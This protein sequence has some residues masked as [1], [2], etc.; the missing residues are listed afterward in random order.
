LGIWQLKA[1]IAM[2]GPITEPFREYLIDDAKPL[3]SS[4]RMY[5]WLY[6]H[7]AQVLV[8]DAARLHLR[9]NCTFCFWLMK[10]YPLAFLVTF[11]EPAERQFAQENLDVFGQDAIGI[12]RLIRLHLRPS[13]HPLWPEA[14]GDES[15]VLY[16][17]E[18]TVT[19]P[20][21][22]IGLP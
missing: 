12:R 18:A 22:S 7:Q 4:I 19:R 8:R 17:P 15:V 2:A 6:P 1:S 10:F 11:D 14:P 20:A 21:G 9:S 3:P 16:G 5:Y 13:V